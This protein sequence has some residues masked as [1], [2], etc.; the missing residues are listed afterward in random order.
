MASRF[1]SASADE[2]CC[3][4][5]CCEGTLRALKSW[6]WWEGANMSV[7]G[8]GGRRGRT[9]GSVQLLKRVLLFPELGSKWNVENEVITGWHCRHWF[10]LCLQSTKHFRAL[11]KLCLSPDFFVSVQSLSGKCLFSN[12]VD[13]RTCIMKRGHN[14]LASVF[15]LD[16]LHLWSLASTWAQVEESLTLG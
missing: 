10:I 4:F 8:Q 15:I 2:M 11:L 6:G 16:S 13:A 5:S 12:A 9:R 3:V 7:P 14:G 1:G